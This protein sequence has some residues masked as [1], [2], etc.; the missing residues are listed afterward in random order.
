MVGRLAHQGGAVALVVTPFVVAGS[1]VGDVFAQA[2][3]AVEVLFCFVRPLL[4]ENPVDIA[5]CPTKNLQ[6]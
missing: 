2:G 3:Y 1:V 6:H 4:K 5:S